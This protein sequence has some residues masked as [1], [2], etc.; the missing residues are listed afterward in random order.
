VLTGSCGVCNFG[1]GPRLEL[2]SLLRS[3]IAVGSMIASLHVMLF[4]SNEKETSTCQYVISLQ[5]GRKMEGLIKNEAGCDEYHV[6]QW[7]T[8]KSHAVDRCFFL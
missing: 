5:F 8:G 2:K 6:V 3:L 1:G 4:D 7:Y